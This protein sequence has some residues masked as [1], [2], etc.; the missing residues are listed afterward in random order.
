MRALL[1]L[2]LAAIAGAAVV[3]AAIVC[4]A[5]TAPVARAAVTA[6]AFF[7]EGTRHSPTVSPDGRFIAYAVSVENARTAARRAA[8]LKRDVTIDNV[9]DL[10][11]AQMRAEDIVVKD[12][13]TGA[14]VSRVELGGRSAYS[15]AWGSNAHLLISAAQPVSRV[16]GNFI[17]FEVGARVISLD[18]RTND[19]VL[20]FDNQSRVLG[21]N[22]DL[23]GVVSL[24]PGQPDHIL[25]AAA[26]SG[27]RDLWRVNLA[28]GDATRIEKGRRGT[29]RWVTDGG[30]RAV[31]RLDAN[32]RRTTLTVYARNA[33]GRW[34]NVVTTRWREDAKTPPAFWPIGPGRDGAMYVL[35]LADGDDRYKIKTF[36]METGALGET[37]ID[38]PDVDMLDGLV[39]HRTGLFL[40]AVK[41]RDRYEAVFVD[42]TLQKHY[43]ALQRFFDDDANVSINEVSLSSPYMALTV[44]SP[45]SPGEFYLYDR[46]RQRVD[47][48]FASYPEDLV[49]ALSPVE[50][51]QYT[52]RDGLAV[53]GYLTHPNGRRTGAAPLIV[54]P[55]GGPEVR[56]YYDYDPFAQY[57]ASLGYR[58][59]QPNFRGSAG[60][61][62]R[63]AEAGYGEWGGKMQDDVTD[64]VRALIERGLVDRERVA[65]VGF[66]YGG[67]AALYASATQGDVYACAAS[68]SG[69]TDL[70]ELLKYEREQE[71]PASYAYGYVKKAIGDPRRDRDR[72][73]ATSPARLAAQIDMPVLIAHGRLDRVVPFEQAE[74]MVEALRKA[75]KPYK[76][77]EFK[78]DGHSLANLGTR[79]SLAG[80]VALFLDRCFYD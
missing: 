15:L 66:S 10:Q 7:E 21:E 5:A 35:S 4:A 49:E 26:R 55:H 78:R 16:S 22:R 32:R 76:F 11:I 74:L 33:E 57:L 72:L 28:T 64:G 2:V 39:D 12:I 75:G 58:V 1:R 67:Y 17:V 77:L 14:L 60:F 30:G 43:R 31:F 50:P 46:Q 37:V 23:S 20:L 52:A 19:V 27:D 54:M 34:N 56:D 25:M 8:A 18:V 41:I 47:S 61:G 38:D 59:F 42:P 44:S 29:F 6:Q 45:Q 69:V 24:L 40:G 13:Q 79:V 73:R 36:D 53:T 80:D 3:C 68:V 51:V 9:A 62:R 63:F 65:I 70:P 71:G 48:F